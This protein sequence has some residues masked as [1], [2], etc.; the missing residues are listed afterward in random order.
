MSREFSLEQL[1]DAAEIP[2]RT[3]RYYIARGL[4]Q[5]PVKAG[6]AA[7]YANDHLARLQQIKKL[8]AQGRTLGEI[9]GMLAPKDA[10]AATAETSPWW[11]YEV[12]KDV[13]VMARADVSPWR[14]RL[15]REAVKELTAR[16]MA[17]STADVEEEDRT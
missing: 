12:A 15:I 2:A 4:M 9:A 14:S 5:G 11:R 7:A 13:I 16:L 3:I 17:P 8:Q 1:A 10:G 6:R